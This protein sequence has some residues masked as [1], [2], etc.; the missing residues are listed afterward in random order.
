MRS[1]CARSSSRRSSASKRRSAS[2]GRPS[3]RGSS[4]RIVGLRVAAQA[5][6]AADPLHV[7]ADDAGA[8]GR[9][10][11][12]GEREPREVS[13]PR[14]VAVRERLRDL[15]AQRLEVD[16]V[17]GRAAA[18]AGLADADLDRR[19]L[20][21]AEQEAL[22]DEV[23]DAAVL[24]GLGERRGE[25]P[26]E[27]GA[28]APVDLAE[29]GERVEQL[30]GPDRDPLGAQLVAEREQ[31]RVDAHARASPTRS[32]TSSTSV[33]CLTI[34]DIVSRTSVG[35][36]VLRAEQQQRTGPVDRLGDR[37]RLLEVELAHH[38]DHLDELARDGLGQLGRVQADDRE[39]VLDRRVV[40][41]EVQAAALERL[42][43]LAR[44]V[45]GQDHDRLRA[46]RD[47]AQLGDRDLEVREQLEQHRLE[48]LVGLVDLVD[49]QHDRLGG[50][51]RRE[52]RPGEQEL[53][54]EDVVL[55]LRPAGVVGLGLDPQ[56]LL[57]V[58]P[59]V[60]RLGLVE[61]LVALQPHERRARGRSRAPARARS[62]R[63][64]RDPRRAPACPGASPDRRRA[65]STRRGG[66]PPRAAPRRPRR[67]IRGARPFPSMIGTR[68]RRRRYSS[69]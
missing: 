15:R 30:G 39:L 59:L 13:Q 19:G 1:I 5:E 17:G 4:A 27:G 62:C 8:L 21:R 16:L 38:R 12:R 54:A 9:A 56:Q 11:E 25:R 32:A 2:R 60:E 31:L 33:R 52:Q 46:R 48:L 37:R 57:A 43:Q 24:G 18:R 64:R 34:T 50:P 28:L 65:R 41:P 35:V 67:P 6:R 3:W 55:D 53:L 29:R 44:V 69:K 68:A 7:D 26:L 51:D 66:S 58:V 45:R 40:E 23:E 47:P 61:P 42:G 10:P 63:P 20:R 36:Q 22:E 49:Q 14:L